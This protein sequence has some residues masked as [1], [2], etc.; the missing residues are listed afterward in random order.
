[1]AAAAEA[2]AV[3][4]HKLIRQRAS[5]LPIARLHP[6]AGAPRHVTRIALAPLFFELALCDLN[7]G[8]RAGTPFR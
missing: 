5:C 3:L 2:A 6:G 7:P 4:T 8:V 1:V